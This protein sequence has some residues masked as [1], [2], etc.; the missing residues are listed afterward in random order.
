MELAL[1]DSYKIHNVF[2]VSLLKKEIPNTFAHRSALPPPPPDEV[3]GEL[4]FEVQDILDSRF[5]GPKDD[6]VLHYLT[7]FKGYP[8]WENMWLPVENLENCKRKVKRFHQKFPHKPHPET[9]PRSIARVRLALLSST[10][11]NYLL[12][13]ILQNKTLPSNNQLPYTDNDLLL[14]R[15]TSATQH[16]T[17]EVFHSV[18]EG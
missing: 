7:S 5:Q 6:R 12:P 15:S 4:E 2:H 3:D 1:P 9:K 8:K 11:I 13:Q 18:G 16:S 10:A 17:M 14:P